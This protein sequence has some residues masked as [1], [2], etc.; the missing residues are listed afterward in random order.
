MDGLSDDDLVL[1]AKSWEAMVEVFKAWRTALEK[2]GVKVNMSKSKIL[3]SGK[4]TKPLRT[5]RYPCVVR[6]K[7]GG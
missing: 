5:G 2:R 3:V 1:T 7:G 4:R 6:D